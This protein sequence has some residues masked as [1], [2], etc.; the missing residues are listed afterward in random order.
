[1]DGS[2]VKIE[3]NEQTTEK[4]EFKMS[5]GFI[6]NIEQFSFTDN[7]LEEYIDRVEQSFLVNKVEETL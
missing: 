1:M 7:D 3:G 5:V 4:T 6:G 2:A